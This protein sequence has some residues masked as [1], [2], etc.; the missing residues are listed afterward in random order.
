[1][2]KL[3]SVVR[4]EY[5]T[6]IK[7]PSFWI[8]LALV[9][10]LIAIVVTFSIIGNIA[11]SEKIKNLANDLKSVALVDESDLIS[12]EV[13][14]SAEL[15][16]HHPED[17]EALRQQVQNGE[18]EALVVY[19]KNITESKTYIAYVSNNDFTTISGVTSLADNIL[20]ISVF[21]P[22]ESPEI[23]ALAQNGASSQVVSYKN[24]Q[25]TAGINEYVAPAIFIV[26]FYIVFG[27]SVGYMLTSVSEEKENRSMEIVLTYVQPRT[28][29]LGKLLGVSLVTLTQIAFFIIAAVAGYIIL[30]N[31]QGGVALPA[32]VELSRV[33]LHAAPIFFGFA[34]LIVGFLM[35]AGLMTATAAAAPS[36]KEA[37]S[38]SSIFFISAFVPFYFFSL[39][40][41][42]PENAIV[43]FMTFFPLTSPVVTLIRNTVGN[44]SV[45]EST[46]ALIAMTIA[47]L[48]SIY[49]AARAFKL[50]ALEFG[51]AIKISKLLKK[52]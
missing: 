34:F 49:L 15:T 31:I 17:S 30:N 41:T 10:L 45:L 29:M 21:L 33:T 35:F 12:P 48:L 2:A 32:G 50:G 4:H 3:R 51:S 1:M 47:M 16:L 18:L 19:P 14:K 7:Q 36:A 9:P 43:K 39:I 46:L 24:G 20:K 28:L 27:F 40:V 22:L 11:S 23:I 13:V 6:I 5:T 44:M 8:T 42:S 52:S 38:F 25:E 37:G 26:L